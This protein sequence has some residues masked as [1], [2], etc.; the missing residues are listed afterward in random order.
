[1][2][3]ATFV[4]SARKDYP[5]HGIKKGES[6][7][8]WAFMQGGRGGAK[9]FSKTQPKPS[10]LTQSEFWGSVLGLQEDNESVPDLDDIESRIED[11]KSDIETWRDEQEERKSNLPDSLQDGSSGELL[12]SRYDALDECANTL[13][14]VDFSYEQGEKQD[15]ESDEEY[16]TRIEEEKQSR[17]EEIWN[18]VTDALSSISCD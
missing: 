15:G 6:Y 12:Q 5:E 9:R 3:R 1:M 14:S 2:A 17:A 16:E 13:D 11:I 8:H 7:W 4:K 10:Q 18:E